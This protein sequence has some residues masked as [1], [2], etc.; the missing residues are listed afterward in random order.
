MEK[1]GR[2]NLILSFRH[3][4][5]IFEQGKH[6]VY[7]LSFILGSYSIFSYHDYFPLLYS[8][9]VLSLKRTEIYC[10]VWR[11]NYSC[12]RL[13]ALQYLRAHQLYPHYQTTLTLLTLSREICSDACNKVASLKCPVWTL[14]RVQRSPVSL[15]LT[16]TSIQQPAFWHPKVRLLRAK[17][18]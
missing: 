4:Y 15:R 12:W 18:N 11:S 14:L 2:V 8:L 5:I 16:I 3:L 7:H 1:H 6:Y 9:R 10:Q 13:K 17:D